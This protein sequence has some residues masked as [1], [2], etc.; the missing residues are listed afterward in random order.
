MLLDLLLVAVSWGIFLGWLAYLEF[1]RKNLKE[2]KE[3]IRTAAFFLGAMT[4]IY[5]LVLF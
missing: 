1:I 3:E 2:N 4:L 5:W